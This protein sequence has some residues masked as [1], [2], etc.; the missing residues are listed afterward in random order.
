MK[1]EKAMIREERLAE[2]LKQIKDENELGYGLLGGDE[3]N[4]R[5]NDILAPFGLDDHWETLT[6]EFG[7]SGFELIANVSRGIYE[8]LS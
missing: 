6:E 8:D 4:G 1:I 2:I 3:D 5:L 7:E